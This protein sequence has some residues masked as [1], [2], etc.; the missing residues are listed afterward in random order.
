MSGAFDR[1]PFGNIETVWVTLDRGV[2]QGCA[3]SPLLFSLYTEE[4]V[5]RVK[6]SG[7]RVN[8]NGSK[9]NI[10][11]CA[12][13]IVLIAENKDMIQ[14]MLNIVIDYGNKFSMSFNNNKCGV[15]EMNEPEGGKKM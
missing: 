8:V 9:I 2:G 10:I 7:L 1:L 3:L 14:K 12:D 13:D 4:L 6:E 11:L 5:A 15:M